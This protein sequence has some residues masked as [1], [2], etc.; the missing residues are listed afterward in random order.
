M[1]DWYDDFA[2]SITNAPAPAAETPAPKPTSFNEAFGSVPLPQPPPTL[3]GEV[4]KG[5]AAGGRSLAATGAGLVGLAGDALGSTPMKQWGLDTYQDQQDAIAKNDAPAVGSYKDIKNFGDF[6]QYAAYQLSK[7]LTEMAPLVALGGVGGRIAGGVAEGAVEKAVQYGVEKGLTE[8]ASKQLVSAAVARGAGNTALEETLGGLTTGA[9]ERIGQDAAADTA[10]KGLTAGADKASAQFWGAQAGNAGAMIGQS[11]GDEYGQT[12]DVG[13]SLG[14]GS[15]EGAINAAAMGIVAAPVFRSALGISAGEATKGFGQFAAKLGKKVGTDAAVLGGI[16]Y[17]STA[18]SQYAQANVDPNYDPNSAEAQQQRIE[19]M[20]GGAGLGAAFGAMGALEK[21][22]APLTE[23]ALQNLTVMKDV[24]GQI[25]G[26]HVVDGKT[27]DG[28][29]VTPEGNTVPRYSQTV[30]VTHNGVT[31]G[32]QRDNLMGNWTVPDPSHLKDIGIDADHYSNIDGVTHIDGADSGS[33]TAVLVHRAQNALDRV[34]HPEWFPAP[35]EATSA[36]ANKESSEGVGAGTVPSPDAKVINAPSGADD[37]WSDTAQTYKY[38]QLKAKAE[39]AGEFPSR[40]MSFGE[41]APK[42]GEP[43]PFYPD[44]ERGNA[45]W[46]KAKAGD[47]FYTPMEDGTTGRVVIS[48]EGKD[49]HAFIYGDDSDG[50]HTIL[51]D[52]PVYLP[53]KTLNPEMEGYQ[54][55]VKDADGNESFNPELSKHPA[56][57]NAGELN[58]EA[59]KLGAAMLPSEEKETRAGFEVTSDVKNARMKL[60]ASSPF[61]YDERFDPKSIQSKIALTNDLREKHNETLVN[62]TLK[63]HGI[64]GLSV[65]D[66]VTVTVPGEGP[67]EGVV[68]EHPGF[69]EDGKI[70]IGFS[71]DGGSGFKGESSIRLTPDQWGWISK[72]HSPAPPLSEVI[73][74]QAGALHTPELLAQRGFCNVTYPD[75]TTAKNIKFT[76]DLP[77]PDTVR[78]DPRDA[79]GTQLSPA[80][81]LIAARRILVKA[82]NPKTYGQGLE[83][84]LK[85]TGMLPT[86][87]AFKTIQD[88]AGKPAGSDH[89]ETHGIF[90]GDKE[91]TVRQMNAGLEVRAPKDAEIDTDK[92]VIHRFPSYTEIKGVKDFDGHTWTRPNGPESFQMDVARGLGGKL[93]QTRGLYIHDEVYNSSAKRAERSAIRSEAEAKKKKD[94]EFGTPLEPALRKLDVDPLTPIEDHFLGHALDRAVSHI[95][96]RKTYAQ[97]VRD[98]ATDTV[99]AKLVSAI[100]SNRKRTSDK[101]ITPVQN[102]LARKFVFSI[103]KMRD[104]KVAEIR[105]ARDAAVDKAQATGRGR[106]GLPKGDVSKEELGT[107]SVRDAD[108]IEKRVAAAKR[109]R[110]TASEMDE[111]VRITKL[112]LTDKKD[113]AFVDK[114]RDQYRNLEGSVLA[115]SHIGKIANQ[116]LADAARES[117]VTH[118]AQVRNSSESLD[119]PEGGSPTD[120]AASI[121]AET[122]A[123]I[124]TQESRITKQIENSPEQTSRKVALEDEEHTRSTLGTAPEIAVHDSE[125]PHTDINGSVIPDEDIAQLRD[126]IGNL[127]DED[128]DWLRKYESRSM[129][130]EDA[131]EGTEQL[132]HS[133]DELESGDPARVEAERER[134]SQQAINRL[135]TEGPQN[136]TQ[137]QR[138]KKIFGAIKEQVA[139]ESAEDTARKADRLTAKASDA[140]GPLSPERIQRNQDRLIAQAE[141]NRGVKVAGKSRIFR[142]RVAQEPLRT[143]PVPKQPKFDRPTLS[144]LALRLLGEDTEN[145]TSRN[146]GANDARSNQTGS[147]SLAPHEASSRGLAS[148]SA[149]DSRS[150]NE[151]APGW[152]RGHSG[153][154]S[155]SVSPSRAGTRGGHSVET[156]AGETRSI[157]AGARREFVRSAARLS[158]SELEKVSQS[159]IDAAYDAL[160][161]KAH[162]QSAYANERIES[163][164]PRIEDIAHKGIKELFEGAAEERR[165]LADPHRGSVIRGNLGDLLRSGAF[166]SPSDFLKKVSSGKL[167]G[168][169]QDQVLK[170]KAILNASGKVNWNNVAVQAGLF[171]DIPSKGGRAPWSALLTRENLGGKKGSGHNIY[172]NLDANANRGMVGS[173][174]HELGHV[175]EADKVDGKI[176]MGP[177]EQKSLDSIKAFYDRC[178]DAVLGPDFAREATPAEIASAMKEHAKGEG[179]NAY[180]HES[181]VSIHEFING[182]QDNP[183]LHS[184]LT[185]EYGIGGDAIGN[186]IKEADIKN[187]YT[188]LTEL[189]LG[190][191]VDPS[192]ELARAFSKAWQVTHKGKVEI[193]PS[194]LHADLARFKSREGWINEQLQERDHAGTS[195]ERDALRQEWEDTNKPRPKVERQKTEKPAKTEKSAV[196]EKPAEVAPV[197]EPPTPTV[198]P[199]APVVV[200]ETT[201]TPRRPR[202]KRTVPPDHPEASTESPLDR[203]HRKAASLSFEDFSKLPAFDTYPPS[204]ESYEAMR[205]IGQSIKDVPKPPTDPEPPTTPPSGGKGKKTEPAAAAPTT[206]PAAAPTTESQT[207]SAVPLVPPDKEIDTSKVDKVDGLR[208][209]LEEKFPKIADADKLANA[210]MNTTKAEFLKLAHGKG[211]DD[212]GW[213]KDGTANTLLEA[214]YEYLDSLKD[215]SGLSAQKGE[216]NPNWNPMAPLESAAVRKGD[217]EPTPSVREYFGHDFPYG[218]TVRS[219]DVGDYLS[220]NH[221]NGRQQALWDAMKHGREDSMPSIRLTRTRS[222]FDEKGLPTAALEDR[223]DPNASGTF[224]SL[225]NHI[226]L[227]M[228]NLGGFVGKDASEVFLHEMTHAITAKALN[229]SPEYKASIRELMSLARSAGVTGYGMKSS[230]EFLAEAFANSKFQTQ[231]RN[232]PYRGS[233]TESIFDHFVKWVGKVIGIQGKGSLLEETLRRGISVSEGADIPAPDRVAKRPIPKP[234]VRMSWPG[235]RTD[236]SRPLESAAVRDTYDRA[237]D[238]VGT[239]IPE[240]AKETFGGKLITTYKGVQVKLAGLFGGPDK[241]VQKAISHLHQITQGI[242]RSAEATV[243]NAHRNWV[244]AVKNE[245]GG[246][247]SDEQLKTARTALG[248]YENDL[249][250]KDV[251]DV[252]AMKA[253]KG[254]DAATQLARQRTAMNREAARAEQER[255]LNSL[256]PLTRAAIVKYRDA[257]DSLQE[258]VVKVG[259]ATGDLKATIEANKGI[260]ITRSYDHL[261]GETTHADIVKKNPEL[262]RRMET[263][264]RDYLTNQRKTAF[265]MDAR[266]NGKAL[267]DA[268]ATQKAADSVTNE[269]VHNALNSF[270]SIKDPGLDTRFGMGRFPGRQDLSTFKK[271]GQLT[272]DQREYLGERLDPSVIAADTISKQASMLANHAFLSELREEG[273]KDGTFYDPSAPENLGRGVPNGYERVASDKN[274]NMEP[275]SGLF[276]HKDVGNGLYHMLPKLGAKDTPWLLDMFR[277]VT[278]YS[279]GAKTQFSPA[280]QV[281]HNVSNLLGLVTTANNIKHL[282]SAYRKINP[283]MNLEDA[284]AALPEIQRLNRLGLLHQSE[285]NRLIHD[286]TS[287]GPETSLGKFLNRIT[288]PVLDQEVRGVKMRDIPSTL[289]GVSDAAYKVAIFYGECEKYASAFPDWSQDQVEK[290]AADIA[291]Q[292]HWTYDRSPA[293]V[294]ELSKVPLVAPFVRFSSEVFRTSYNLLKLATSEIKEGNRTGNAELAKMGWNRMKG[295]STVALGP[296]ALI[297]MSQ[298][299]SGM[300]NDDQEALRKFQPEWQQNSQ[301]IPYSKGDGKVGYFDLSWWNHYHILFAPIKAAVRAIHNSDDTGEG[302]RNAMVDG[303]SQLFEPFDREQLTT[304]AIMDLARNKNSANGAPIYNPQGSAADI[305]TAVASR[306]WTALS[307]GAM[308][309][310]NRVYKGATGYVSDSGRSYDAGHELANMIGWRAADTDIGNALHFASGKFTRDSQDATQLLSHAAT[311]MGSRTPEQ[312]ISGYESANAAHQRLVEDLREKYTAAIQLGMSPE[313]VQTALKGAHVTQNVIDQ[314]AGGY[315]NRLTPSSSVMKLLQSRGQTDRIEALNSAVQAAPE[316]T[317]LPR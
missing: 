97:E 292:C 73:R 243:T 232:I 247:M 307:P 265:L 256:P 70:R 87:S 88:G 98:R 110:L 220:A 176:K 7:N 127:S 187:A 93:A 24:P 266:K 124:P 83:T 294:K 178:L 26:G 217:D 255:A 298:A 188:S 158:D 161:S 143:N 257:I 314:V 57:L 164:V 40:A 10:V 35:T 277:K 106:A 168:I 140:L 167:N 212:W 202:E 76:A 269:D 77:V 1:G 130:Q 54:A 14:Y 169:P 214:K 42:A 43:G 195:A 302:I 103:N 229:E 219:V 250:E 200:K 313:Q 228:Q 34:E 163:G 245:F 248:N 271:R 179:E 275:L 79:K 291:L 111:V 71:M 283:F 194:P 206:E 9:G 316:R 226:D 300:T 315:Y 253:S 238:I 231:L 132:Q 33:H 260:Y 242:R 172:L 149:P 21:A 211:S 20:V 32:M 19:A 268:E 101:P 23:Q 175:L 84:F 166:Q 311:S 241:G 49:K 56:S 216:E 181:L 201:K 240:G 303:I 28:D 235:V 165:T 287:S 296:S 62:N 60:G 191:R 81:A 160:N 8:T 59:S 142:D 136:K 261:D 131:K 156:A 278:G 120:A 27:L 25:D 118:R 52:F 114:L 177:I 182:L 297:A 237:K 86:R 69:G 290:K 65:G 141:A 305:G 95:A 170:A 239:M 207:A 116:E 63:E 225:K 198:E 146:A 125:I 301:I 263:S 148:A 18:L 227:F 48:G 264:T 82:G 155:R 281:R 252:E 119:H 80:K 78:R 37:P 16:A 173:Y 153:D 5:I 221:F 208:D 254:T 192:S 102:E 104:Q 6:G 115:D 89:V 246:K 100:K 51:K 233:K 64:T 157:A 66:P 288:A 279:M 126:A 270:L 107:V 249:S 190:R 189:T 105:A 109:G 38:E 154:E 224:Y 306:L 218:K 2:S 280:A 196:A 293:I 185:D 222:V 129:A 72:G 171:H 162:R 30:P 210:L 308:D 204:R 122:D 134:L 209:F 295:I 91:T 289:Y 236:E 108:A 92:F 159:E 145:D 15:L 3:L 147:D 284:N 310:I 68:T 244:D 309:S 184:L 259:L 113:T 4:G 121:N 135:T 137:R 94:A 234:S 138:W 282:G 39:A 90:T 44:P 50:N 180:G 262:A 272:A 67:R 31:V 144:P 61:K 47:V 11:V 285:V 230:H 317:P 203:L 45:L 276:V 13:T 186:P 41:G 17:P 58:P 139:P 53:E 286:L 273:L 29:I 55:F 223:V 251:A 150:G 128:R 267:T 96:S 213:E 123:T 133:K 151:G 99:A 152:I 74:Q 312:V 304:S 193:N 12:K 258:K 36:E 117:N 274:P 183:Y 205:K 174:L 85:K 75:P 46:D 299:A 112:D 215:H 197:V 22:H 199:A